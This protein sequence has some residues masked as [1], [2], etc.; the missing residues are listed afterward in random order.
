MVYFGV[1]LE[2]AHSVEGVSLIGVKG[3]LFILL[4]GFEIYSV[5]YLWKKW[6]INCLGGYEKASPSPR[7]SFIH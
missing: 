6:K 7:R 5:L 4:V 2:L 3:S 1:S